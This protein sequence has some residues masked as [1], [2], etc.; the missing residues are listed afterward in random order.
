MTRSLEVE[1][2]MRYKFG[3]K[4]YVR[5]KMIQHLHIELG[6]LLKLVKEEEGLSVGRWSFDRRHSDTEIN[7]SELK[8]EKW[9]IEGE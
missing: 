7:V 9:D 5:S 1:I 8:G 2:Q 3:G 4:V 6:L